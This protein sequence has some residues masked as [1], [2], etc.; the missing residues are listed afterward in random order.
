MRVENPHGCPGIVVPS[1]NREGYKVAVS[2]AA[3]QW[4]TANRAWVTAT[5]MGSAR[6]DVWTLP[7]GAGPF[8]EVVARVPGGAFCVVKAEGVGKACYK[9]SPLSSLFLPLRKMATVRCE[10]AGAF[11]ARRRADCQ[12]RGQRNWGI[13]GRTSLH[14]EM[15]IFTALTLSLLWWD[16]SSSNQVAC[17]LA[18]SM[19]SVFAR[20]P[21]PPS[22]TGS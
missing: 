15:P 10:M 8:L 2:G 21:P 1:S 16:S 7:S 6:F 11:P 14:S 5:R 3:Y 19:R 4:T 9:R 13:E 12:P 22:R 20:K 18:S 17:K